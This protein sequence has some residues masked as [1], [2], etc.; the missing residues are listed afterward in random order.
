[1]YVCVCKIK[2]VIIM[3]KRVLSRAELDRLLLFWEKTTVESYYYVTVRARTS[4]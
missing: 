3:Q 1:M 4:R 2:S